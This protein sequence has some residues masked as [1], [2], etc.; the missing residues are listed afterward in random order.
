MHVP[1]TIRVQKNHAGRVTDTRCL[2]NLVRRDVN[3]I[4]AL[5]DR[6]WL[7]FPFLL[8]GTVD[9]H[10]ILIRRVPVPGNDAAWI[11]LDQ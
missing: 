6:G 5:C 2:I 10:H 4:S 7:V 8:K 3:K 11:E 1:G 9:H